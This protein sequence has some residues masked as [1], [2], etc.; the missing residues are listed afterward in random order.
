M[1]QRLTA[2]FSTFEDFTDP[3]LSE[4]VGTSCSTCSSWP[5]AARSLAL[6]AGPTSNASATSGSIG[7]G[8]SCDWMAASLRGGDKG[9]FLLCRNLP[10]A[11]LIR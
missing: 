11:S 10:F 7:C 4:P 1:S 8:R 2:V 5:C 3:A 9:T 6:I